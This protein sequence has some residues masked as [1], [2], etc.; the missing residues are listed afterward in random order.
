VD[1]IGHQIHVYKKIIRISGKGL[2]ESEPKT[3]KSKRTIKMTST[4]EELLRKVQGTQIGQ[5]DELEDAWVNSGSVFNQPD[6]TAIDPDL[7]TKA[8]KKL[9][10]G[11][12][13]SP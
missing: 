13:V 7:I 10:D 4:L 11:I 1:F 2:V 8:F 9:V 12:S 3:E 5:W 6:G